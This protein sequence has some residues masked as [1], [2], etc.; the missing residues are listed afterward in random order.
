MFFL[1]LFCYYVVAQLCE[2]KLCIY[3]SVLYKVYMRERSLKFCT[4]RR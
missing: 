4:I 3:L 2:K 1:L